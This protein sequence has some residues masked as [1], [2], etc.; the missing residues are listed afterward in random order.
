MK[1]KTSFGLNQVGNTTPQWAKWMFRGTIVVTAVIAF[2]VGGTST[3]S[4]ELKEEML[5]MLKAIDM[6]VFGL[7]KMFG[8]EITNDK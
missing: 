4:S 7:S 1:T 8:I 6:A 2:W 3:L 5:L